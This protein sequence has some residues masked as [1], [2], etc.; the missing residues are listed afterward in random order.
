MNDD[1]T[2]FVPNEVWEWFVM[3]HHVF[4][5]WL[6]DY[7]WPLTLLYIISLDDGSLYLLSQHYSWISVMVMVAGVESSEQ[8]LSASDTSL[9]QPHNTLNNNNISWLWQH[10]L[11]I[12]YATDFRNS[13]LFWYGSMNCLQ[14]LKWSMNW[15]SQ[16]STAKNFC[17]KDS[18]HFWTV[19]VTVS[20]LMLTSVYN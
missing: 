4:H 9:L 10:Q 7:L 20:I 6:S 16:L 13:Q 14:Y 5:A 17:C 11:F 3:G 15:R 8:P 12:N 19:V 18:Y 2:Y 1:L